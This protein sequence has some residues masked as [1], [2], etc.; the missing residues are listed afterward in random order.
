MSGTAA[1][2][3]MFMQRG[4]RSP[5]SGSRRTGP[6]GRRQRLTF[7]GVTWSYR[8]RSLYGVLAE[9]V[10]A[11]ATAGETSITRQKE[12]VDNDA[13]AVE[14]DSDLDGSEA[15]YARLSG[16]ALPGYG[17]GETRMTKTIETVDEEPT[18]HHHDDPSGR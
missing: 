2:R 15:I 7:R 4:F 5:R 16:R 8:G 6:P 3:L 9:L 18:H 10:P 13:E 12:T 14:L 1:K 11:R 17:F